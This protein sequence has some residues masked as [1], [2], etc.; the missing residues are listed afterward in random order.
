M[1]KLVKDLWEKSSTVEYAD[2]KIDLFNLYGVSI[3]SFLPAKKIGGS[4]FRSRKRGPPLRFS[5]IKKEDYFRNY[6]G[7]Q[8]L[9][10]ASG[11]G[12]HW[13]I[14]LWCVPFFPPKR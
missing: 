1:T 9:Y 8:G 11:F 10:R 14:F 6:V 7:D 4:P 2:L 5:L 12:G 13:F 3:M